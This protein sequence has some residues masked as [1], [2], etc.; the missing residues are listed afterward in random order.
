MF[1]THEIPISNGSAT[2][3]SGQQRANVTPWRS[4][5]IA[6]TLKRRL[7]LADDDD[8]HHQSES[9]KS[10]PVA[11]DWKPA[12][13]SR[14]KNQVQK[15]FEDLVADCASICPHIAQSCRVVHSRV[16]EL[17]HA[18]TDAEL[19]TVSK[20]MEIAM[21]KGIEPFEKCENFDDR[22]GENVNSIVAR[23]A[24]D[25]VQRQLE[26]LVAKAS[27]IVAVFVQLADD[28]ETHEAKLN[29]LLAMFDDMTRD[30]AEAKHGAEDF[31][32]A[33]VK[34]HEELVAKSSRHE[35]DLEEFITMQSPSPMRGKTIAAS[36]HLSM[37]LDVLQSGD[38]KILQLMQD[39]RHAVE[40]QRIAMEEFDLRAKELELRKALC[41]LCEVAGG[42][43]EENVNASRLR[44]FNN[45][46]KTLEDAFAHVREV[47]AQLEI[48]LSQFGELQKQ[49]EQS[50]TDKL[51]K[52]T[53]DLEEHKRLYGEDEAPT[54][55]RDL[56]GRIAE[57]SEVVKRS[58]QGVSSAIQ[59]Q[60]DLW[61][62]KGVPDQVKNHVQQRLGPVVR[63]MPFT[64]DVSA[65]AKAFF[66]TMT[67]KQVDT[68]ASMLKTNEHRW[69][70]Y[71][72][73]DFFE[74][75]E[76]SSAASSCA[77]EPIPTA[78]LNLVKP[79]E[80]KQDQA[81][82]GGGCVVM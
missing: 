5:V 70:G 9:A 79:E 82:N 62:S 72:S 54:E 31:L 30:I 68:L 58:R 51:D 42:N 28:V 33:V 36:R 4:S 74:T 43:M 61:S 73:D 49:R 20:L 22:F 23:T 25:P 1:T 46:C 37:T 10:S 65:K 11:A 76:T 21:L 64:E 38:P 14:K 56:E 48:V 66:F 75:D 32:G 41:L 19:E 77:F 18:D 47:V 15:N 7:A 78:N 8:D 80:L 39:R 27:Q 12:L 29:S 81:E 40:M 2:Q 67:A 60:A 3:K 35:R 26:A 63:S 13:P 34:R 52:F 57:F 17:A 59:Q 24:K 16:K 55:R 6:A 53:R 44:G 69:G 50:A 71:D 45:R